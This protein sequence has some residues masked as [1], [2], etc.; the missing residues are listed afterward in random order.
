MMKTVLRSF[1]LLTVL[2]SPLTGQDVPPKHFRFLPL[3]ELPK[4]DDELVNDDERQGIR[5]GK[6]P[7]PGSVPP[8]D[9]SILS[10]EADLAIDL[11]L[12]S[13]TERVTIDGETPTL[14][15]KEGKVG[16]GVPWLNSRM[17]SSNLNL[18]V[19]YRD[20]QA[21]TWKQPKMLLLKDDATSFPA[22]KIRLANV[23]DRMILVQIGDP[24]AKPTPKIFGV[25]AGQA[26]QKPLKV[27]KNQI[28][29]GYLTARRTK[30]WIWQNEVVLQANQRLQTFFYKAQGKDPRQRVLFRFVPEPLPKLP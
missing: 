3:G 29:V 13:F 7:P 11:K 1:L 14:T 2:S 19:L 23:S 20:P 9:A 25:P 28:R 6:E 26:V 30:Q 15:L 27:G 22:G 16:A 8:R 21:M 5:V 17:P 24:E 18:G 12:G 10:G 4:W